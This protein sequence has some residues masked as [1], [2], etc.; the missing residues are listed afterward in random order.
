MA[1]HCQMERAAPFRDN[2]RVGRSDVALRSQG[3][4]SAVGSGAYGRGSF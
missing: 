2:L 4:A 3:S 1:F